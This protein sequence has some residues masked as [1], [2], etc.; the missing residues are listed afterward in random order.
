MDDDGIPATPELRLKIAAKVIERA[1]SFGI[2]L[3]DVVIDPLAM[4]MGADHTSGLTTLNLTMP[5]VCI[6]TGTVI[7]CFQNLMSPV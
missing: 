1:A 3:E 7:W 2:P 4:T 5:K 6:E